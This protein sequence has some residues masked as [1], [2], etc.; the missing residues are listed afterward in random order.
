M[1]ITLARPAA[2]EALALAAL[3]GAPSA[4]CE[5]CG[6]VAPMSEDRARTRWG[7]VLD[8]DGLLVCEDCATSAGPG[9]PY[10]RAYWG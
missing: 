1:T 4:T 10:D 6:D 5:S 9:G 8:V 7:W 3:V 2:D